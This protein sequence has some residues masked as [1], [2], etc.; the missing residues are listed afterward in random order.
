[1]ILNLRDAAQTRWLGGQLGRALQY[2]GSVP[3]VI[4]LD[5]DLGTGKTTF[6]SGVLAAMGIPGPVRSP[7]YTLVEPYEAAGRAIYH[8]DLYR[9]S[10]PEDLEGLGIRDLHGPGC[11]LLIEWAERGGQA[12]PP[13]DLHLKFRYDEETSRFLTVTALSAPGQGLAATLADG[14][15]APPDDSLKI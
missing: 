10:G 15:P 14:L 12:L 1:M 2:T 5:G 4:A 9:L 6:V 3:C 7:T 11:I 8:L 13:V